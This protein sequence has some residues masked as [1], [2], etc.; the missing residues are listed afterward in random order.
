[1]NSLTRKLRYFVED[2]YNQRF[3]ARFSLDPGS[4]EANELPPDSVANMVVWLRNID[5]LISMVGVDETA[6]FMDLGCGT[7]IALLYAQQKYDF[8]EFLGVEIQPDLVK[9]S[10]QNFKRNGVRRETNVI[11]ADVR[12]YE[13]PNSRHFLFLFNPF[14][15][16][17]L[18]QFLGTNITTLRQSKSVM[19][20]ANDHLATVGLEFGRVIARDKNFRLTALQFESDA[21]WSS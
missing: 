15:E 21:S 7:G 6:T 11:C 9:L 17:T 16:P 14:G 5:R 4:P 19:L 10:N 12:L 18:R 20:I 3:L 8:K 1:M 2:R 13:L